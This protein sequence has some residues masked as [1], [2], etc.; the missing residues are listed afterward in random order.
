MEIRPLT[1][2]DLDLLADIDATIESTRYL[3]VHQSGEGLSLGWSLE[4]RTLREKFIQSNPVDDNAAFLFRQIASGADEGLALVAEHQGMLVASML[5]HLRPDTRT[6]R[7]VDLRVDSDYRRQGIGSALVFQSIREARER[8]LRAVKAVSS[9]SNVPAAQ[10]L[11]KA[12]FEPTGLDL[13]R[14]SNHDL[15]KEV[16]TLFWYASLD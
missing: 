2:A 11:L 6:L 12:G 8:E 9:T 13:K 10:F 14:T 3:H 5:A 1:L 16:V 7:L 4:E 15:V